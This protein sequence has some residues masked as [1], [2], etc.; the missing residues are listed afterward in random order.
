MTVNIHFP[1]HLYIYI[2]SHITPGSFDRIMQ[3]ALTIAQYEA[4][5]ADTPDAEPRRLSSATPRTTRPRSPTTDVAEID[6]G[7][8]DA[9]PDLSA[10]DNYVDNH[11][12]H[13]VEYTV[14]DVV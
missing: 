4:D 6:M 11:V 9:N 2:L 5:M 10:A 8:E 12:D 13:H 1:L 14:A 7:F 3:S